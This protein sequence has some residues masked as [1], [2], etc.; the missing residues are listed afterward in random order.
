MP[1]PRLGTWT[2]WHRRG[3]GLAL[4]VLL[5][6]SYVFAVRPVRLWMAEHVAFPILSAIETPRSATMEIARTA[7]RPDAVWAIPVRLGG[8]AEAAVQEH[9]AEVAEWAAPVGVIFL[10]PALFLVALYPHKPY[11]LWLLAYHLVLGAVSLAVFAVGVGWFEPAFAVYTFSRTYLAEA[12]SLVVPLLLV[13]AGGEVGRLG[14][15]A[16]GGVWGDQ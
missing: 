6:V 16:E 15:G 12:V 1:E 5:F 14:G 3:A 4:A 9:R 2:G 8:D 10:L 11:W 13:L 7:R